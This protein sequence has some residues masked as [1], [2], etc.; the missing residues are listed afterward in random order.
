MTDLQNEQMVLATWMNKDEK[1]SGITEDMFSGRAERA[2]ATLFD[3]GYTSPT[4][5][6]LESYGLCM[7]DYLNVIESYSG[8][9]DNGRLRSRFIMNHKRREKAKEL[10]DMLK[11]VSDMGDDLEGIISVDDDSGIYQG[12]RLLE[13]YRKDNPSDWNDTKCRVLGRILRANG[14]GDVVTIAGRSGTGKTALALQ[15][16]EGLYYG[17]GWKS[18]FVSAEM[19]LG[20]ICNRLHD[21]EWYK[22]CGA[23]FDMDHARDECWKS[24]KATRQAQDFN[25]FAPEWLVASD[26]GLHI[27]RLEAKIRHVVKAFGCKVVCVDYLQ[28]LKGEGKDRRV[29]VS[30]IAQRFKQIAKDNRVLILSLSQTSRANEDGTSPVKLHHLKESGDIEE[31]SD[32]IIGLW[33]GEDN[34]NI[35]THDIKNRK[36]G[37]HSPMALKKIGVYFREYKDG[38][39]QPSYT[40]PKKTRFG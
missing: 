2:L 20:A 25:R 18:Y 14:P 4:T 30:Y 38:E 35:W 12:D 34:E 19:T 10:R 16:M 37:M 13:M 31:A 33:H 3:N 23:V 5:Q 1:P 27:D 21:I 29:E 40:E 36:L 32:L 17:M 22:N 11:R 8:F 24:W 9:D 26:K 15:I 28:L 7:E 6:Q 39:P